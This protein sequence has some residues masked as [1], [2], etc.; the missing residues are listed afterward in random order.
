MIRFVFFLTIIF[1]YSVSYSQS[2]AFKSELS[3]K[4][5]KEII[6][7][8]SAIKLNELF[9]DFDKRIFYGFEN[10]VNLLFYYTENKKWFFAQNYHDLFVNESYGDI[11]QKNIMSPFFKER[12]RLQKFNEKIIDEYLLELFRVL[13]IDKEFDAIKDSDL[14]MINKKV[15]EI[16]YDYI[17]D[18]YYIHLIVFV[19]KYIMKNRLGYGG[20]IIEKDPFRIGEYTLHFTYKDNF[21]EEIINQFLREMLKPDWIREE[22]KEEFNEEPDE[23]DVKMIIDITLD[24]MFGK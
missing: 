23:F 19:G 10:S 11:T 6:K 1:F 21:K 18:H 20:W 12:T 24:D 3:E 14:E 15:K 9:F 8:R 22:V 7:S 5:A 2:K 17:Y 16:G 4:E 13:D